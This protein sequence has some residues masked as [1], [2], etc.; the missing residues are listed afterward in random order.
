[1]VYAI[2]AQG[3]RDGGTNSGLPAGCYD[4]GVPQTTCPTR[5]T[6]T[7]SAGRPPVSTAAC[8]GTA[9]PTMDWKQL[10]T[11]IYDVDI[12]PPSSFNVN[13]GDARIYGVE[14]NVD[15]KINDNWSV[16]ASGSYTDSHLISSPYA[17]FQDNVGER[18]PLRAVL[19]LELEPALRASPAAAAAR[20]C[21]VR[22][23][24]QGRHVERPARRGLQRLSAH[25]AAG[26]HPHQPALRAEP[27]KAATGSPSSTSPISPTRTRSSTATP[28]TSTCAR[29]PTSRASSAC[30]S[31]TALAR[32]RTRNSRRE[33]A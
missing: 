12:C 5:S 11:L 30:A 21:A 15:Y 8:C 13:V 26:V 29:R 7:S 24:A 33:D 25:P 18:L 22:H 23:G 3:F 2:F 4:N 16:Q 6:T 19:Q 32:K 14:S 31:T 10:Q 17:T 27:R 1:M 9:R 20:L 28:A